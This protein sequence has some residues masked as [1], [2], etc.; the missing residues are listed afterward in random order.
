MELK[1]K[2]CM[3]SQKVWFGLVCQGLRPEKQSG[4]YQGLVWFGLLGLKASTTARGHIEVWF[5]RA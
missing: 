4:P 3:S 2:K 1:I 5:V